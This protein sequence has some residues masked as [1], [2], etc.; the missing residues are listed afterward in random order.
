MV[1]SLDS[2]S[3]QGASRKAV[4]THCRT[5]PF[6]GSSFPQHRPQQDFVRSTSI[7]VC[8]KRIAWA[9]MKTF[10]SWLTVRVL[11][12]NGIVADDNPCPA[13]LMWSFYRIG[14]NISGATSI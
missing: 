7:Y 1:K 12:F 3:R 6:F 8:K 14:T 13:F 10:C 9:T 5:M 2:A 11:C 4:F